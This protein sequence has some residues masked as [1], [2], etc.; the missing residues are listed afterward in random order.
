MMLSALISAAVA[1]ASAEEFRV[2]DIRVEGLQRVSAGTVFAALPINV[3][4]DVDTPDLRF[5]TRQL[6][7]TGLFQDVEIMRDG[8]VLVFRIFE[9]PSIAEIELEGNKAIKDEDL[10]NGMVGAGLAEGEIFKKATLEGLAS[11]LERQYFSQG[12]Y[13][14]SVQTEVEELPQN[15]VK[16]KVLVDEGSAAAIKHINING[17]SLFSDEELS[18]QLELET[19][20]WLSWLNSKDKYAQEKLE[21]DLEKL[22]SFYL[23]RGYLNFKVES[24]Q[25]SLSPSR[26][27]IFITINVDEGEKY[28][29]SEVALAGNLPVSEEML[30]RLILLREEQTFSQVLMTTTS[31]YMTQLLGNSGYTFAEVRGIPELDE[32][33]NQ[34]KVT[35]FVDA[36]DRA[37]VRRVEFRGNTGT[38][39]EVLRRE[40]RQLES[41][42][43]ST[44]RIEQGKIRLERLGYFKD[45]QVET[46]EV[47]GTTDQ[48]DVEYK[49]EEQPS[50]SIGGNI[51]Y[52]EYSGV[53]LGANLQQNNFLGTGK[54]VGVNLSYSDYQEM[55]NLSYTDP[56]FTPDGV[57]RGISLFARNMKLN[58]S[59]ISQYQRNNYGFSVDFGWPISEVERIGLSFG[60]LG[61]EITVGRGPAQEISATPLPD[62]LAVDA[63]GNYQFAFQSQLNDYSA[64][65]NYLAAYEAYEN[66]INNDNPDDDLEMPDAVAE[67]NLDDIDLH[68]LDSLDFDPL[69][70]SPDGFLD[71]HGNKF[72]DYTTALSWTRSTLNR[73]QLATRGM[74]QRLMFNATLP[75]SDLNYFKLTYSAQYFK[76]LFSKLTLRLKTKI[77]YGEGYG[78]TKELPFFEN[79]MS[80]GFN[81]VRGYKRNRL[82][83]RVTPALQYAAA[84]CVR[85]SIQQDEDGND[86]SVC[87]AYANVVNDSSDNSADWAL[88]TSPV[89]GRQDEQA[90]GGNVVFE[91]T[92]EVLFPLPF[93]KDQRSVQTGVFVDIG[94]VFDTS[95]HKVNETTFGVD[96]FEPDFKEL[97]GSYGLGVTWLS[98]YGPL[99]FALS[100]PINKSDNFDSEDFE[101]FSFTMGQSF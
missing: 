38:A 50:G 41:A 42:P 88:N 65:Q 46:I 21:G 101:T 24:T 75:G 18:E 91:G 10:M 16:I 25:V 76:P 56:Y 70:H 61:T 44:A 73:G 62:N 83:P 84:T 49:V 69:V 54:R 40:M 45:V 37:Y 81:S 77:G 51:G 27:E 95:C 13:S 19:S 97:R 1:S 34:V 17:N 93:L 43:A 71:V 9:R 94:N 90:I 67:F 58:R 6:F 89:Y 33:T 36:G 28:T 15:R 39:D 52:S 47:P 26:E 22:N 68:T 64:Y 86:Y 8:G 11:E 96:C 100:Q 60:Y 4:E 99:T 20:T 53:M 92:A 57:S 79:F 31:E 85:Q 23:D 3:G 59:W 35:F 74:S 98:P 14:A 55:V 72:N 32:E 2:Q 82:G 12:R 80:G 5:A 63:D 48:I 78:D 66:S 87:D 30:K 7:K 29:V